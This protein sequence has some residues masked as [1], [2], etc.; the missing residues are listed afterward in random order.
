M[1]LRVFIGHQQ[2]IVSS[3]DFDGPALDALVERAVAMAKVAPEDPYCG[4]AEA[5][6]LA[7]DIEAQLAIPCHFEMFEFNT[8]TPAEFEASAQALQVPYRVLRCGERLSL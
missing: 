3:T 1:G 2:A 7:K 8:V 4:I 6:Q 5:A